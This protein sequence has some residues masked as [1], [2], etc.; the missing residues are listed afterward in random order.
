[1]MEKL[2]GGEM[3]EAW[4]MLKGWYRNAEDRAPKPCYDTIA[5]QTAKRA[6]L[7][8]KVQARKKLRLRQHTRLDE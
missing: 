3:Q 5:N 4:R 8:A 2:A 6:E 1:M 7:Y